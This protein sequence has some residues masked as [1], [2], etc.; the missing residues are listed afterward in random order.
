MM[1]PHRRVETAGKRLP[2]TY[3][4]RTLFLGSVIVALTDLDV[5]C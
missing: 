3:A 2:A 1:T 4:A 5:L